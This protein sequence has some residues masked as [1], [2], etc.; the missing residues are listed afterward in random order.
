MISSRADLILAKQDQNSRT[1]MFVY[2]YETSSGINPS[3]TLNFHTYYLCYTQINKI[4]CPFVAMTHVLL[5]KL[6]RFNK[7]FN[8][9]C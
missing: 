5:I 3:R 7:G 8:Y 9:R 6:A 1:L 4:D 2:H